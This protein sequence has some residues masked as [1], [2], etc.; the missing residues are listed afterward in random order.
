MAYTIT[1]RPEARQELLDLYLYIAEQAG[2]ARALGYVSG[3]RQM[4]NGLAEFPRRGTERTDMLPGLR[5]IG[6]KRSASIAFVVDATEVIVL[7]VFYGGR[8]V[9]ADLLDERL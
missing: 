7:G 9:T 2:D 6:Y 3:I 4:I 5:I 1:L 8:D